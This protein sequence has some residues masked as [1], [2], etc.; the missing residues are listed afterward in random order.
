MRTQHIGPEEVLVGAK[1]EL[2]PGLTSADIAEAINATEARMREAVPMA[3][4]IYLEPDL[5]QGAPPAPAS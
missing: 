5:L 1:I 3:R 2:D 4:V